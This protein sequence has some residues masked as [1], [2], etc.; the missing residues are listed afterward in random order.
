VV[1]IVVHTLRVDLH[2][3][4]RGDRRDS[5]R[6]TAEQLIDKAVAEGLDVLAMTNHGEVWH[7]PGAMAYARRCGLLVIPGIEMDIGHR[8]VLLI[9]ADHAAESVSSFD[10]LRAVKKDGQ[11][12]VAPHPFYPSRSSLGEDLRDHLDLFDAIEYS[13]FYCSVVNPNRR[14]VRRARRAGLPVVGSSDCH[15]LKWIGRTYTIVEAD[16]K[17][18]P[19]VIDAVKEG[20]VRVVSEKL[21]LWEF[22][23]SCMRAAIG[24]PI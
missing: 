17:S 20:R 23:V 18:V 22:G 5:I 24:L 4:V 13:F 2:C 1:W 21:S 16:E 12:V 19:A 6:Y 15:R 10:E 9:N 7:N 14:A 3:H 8:H 11:L